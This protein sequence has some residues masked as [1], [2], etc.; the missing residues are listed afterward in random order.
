VVLLYNKSLISISSKF[1][2]CVLRLGMLTDNKSL[3]TPSI[4]IYPALL[5]RVAKAFKDAIQPGTHTK[6]MLEY[7]DCFVGKQGVV[8]N[9]EVNTNLILP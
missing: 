2:S 7:T 9:F 5:S 8:C 1:L 3:I 6:D 4:P